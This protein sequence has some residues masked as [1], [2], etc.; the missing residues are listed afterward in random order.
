MIVGPQNP[1]QD[2]GLRLLAGDELPAVF[3]ARRGAAR[4]S[5]RRAAGARGHRV[6]PTSATNAKF[7]QQASIAANALPL[8]QHP[9]HRAVPSFE[10]CLKE[11]C[12]RRL[13]A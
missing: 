5:T 4:A 2:L 12:C 8:V 6:H 3:I 7:D 11:N 9:P 10:C 13:L 1:D